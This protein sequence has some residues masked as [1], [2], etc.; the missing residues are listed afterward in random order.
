L[1]LK[2]G[3][4][5]VEIKMFFISLKCTWIK[6]L[7]NSHKPW[8][9]I[10]YEIHGSR[11]VQKLLDFGDEYVK[12]VMN[13]SNDFWYDVFQSWMSVVKTMSNNFTTQKLISVLLWYNTNLCVGNK[14]TY[15]KIWNMHGVKIIGDILDEER[16]AFT[17]T[18]FFTKI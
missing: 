9:N 11:V 6:R 5:L 15:V 14:S 2:G 1:S 17:S 8:L 4:K 12:T 7:T 16:K 18:R 3:L 13:Q 10:F